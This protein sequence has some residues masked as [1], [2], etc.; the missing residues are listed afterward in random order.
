MSNVLQ[1]IG[2]QVGKPVHP[3]HIYPSWSHFFPLILKGVLFPPLAELYRRIYLKNGNIQYLHISIKYS[4]ASLATTPVDHPSLPHYQQR[5]A[6]SLYHR[7]MRLQREGDLHLATML[8][9]SALAALPPT[10]ADINAWHRPNLR[11]T[12]QSRYH[13]T[14]NPKYLDASIALSLLVISDLPEGSPQA[15]LT[16]WQTFLANSYH[17]RYSRLGKLDDLEA[18]LRWS[19]VAVDS[20]TSD[21]PLL[22]SRQATLGVAYSDRLHRY[23]NL[24]DIDL[25]LFWATSA[26]SKTP[27]TDV[28]YFARKQNLAAFYADRYKFLDNV[29]DLQRA[30]Q[31]CHEN[32]NGTEI[33]AAR[34]LQYHHNFAF[35]MWLRYLKLGA[36]DD[37]DIAIDHAL[38]SAQRSSKANPDFGLFSGQCAILFLRKYQVLGNLD[39]LEAAAKWN[40]AALHALNGG[41]PKAARYQHN[42]AVVLHRR[43]RRHRDKKDLEMA[44]QWCNTSIEQSQVD[45]PELQ[46][47]QHL[48]GILYQDLF[49]LSS[50]RSHLDTALEIQQKIVSET[51]NGHPDAA[52]RYSSLAAIYSLMYRHKGGINNREAMMKWN[53]AAADAA[54]ADDPQLYVYKNV[55]ALQYL[56]KYYQRY[57]LDHAMQDR[58]RAMGYF[59]KSS[60]TSN[61]DPSVIWDVVDRWARFAELCRSPECLDAYKAAYRTLP[62][63]FWLGSRVSSRHETLVK[64]NVTSITTKA[65]SACMAFNNLKLAVEFVEQS[66][67]LTFQQLLDLQID[68]SALEDKFP[69]HAYELQGVSA[70]LQSIA[71]STDDEADLQRKLAMERTA[72]LKTIR[73][74]PKFEN[75][76]LPAPF[77][78][79]VPAAQSGPV[80]VI[81]CSEDRCDALILRSDGT[82]IQILLPRV[83][84][85]VVAQQCEKL[86]SALRHY[87][88]HSR[89]M[90]ELDTDRA[91]RSAFLKR[92]N[93]ETIL[94]GVLTWVWSFIVS[95]IFQTLEANGIVDGRIW[96]C[97]TGSLTYLPLHAAGPQSAYVQSYTSTLSALIR[98]RSLPAPEIPAKVIAVGLSELG[99]GTRP[100]LPNVKLEIEAL[101]TAAGE[102]RVSILLNEEATLERVTDLLPQSSWL[103]LACHGRQGNAQDPLKSG[104]LL[105][106]NKKLELERLINTPIPRAEFVFLSACE[107]AMGDTDMANESLHLAGGMIFAGFKAAI[108]TLW[109]IN[110]LDGPVVAQ[111]VYSYLFKNGQE[112]EVTDTA[113][114]LHLAVNILREKGVPPHR[115]V[116]FI[117]IGI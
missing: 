34:P 87:G 47:R 94:N 3:S 95:P 72:L 41:H 73:E 28:N 117:H 16:I 103:H 36:Y 9:T 63:L 109:S 26:V 86:R 78:S 102:N 77:T 74:I 37:L 108:G 62:E 29:E 46:Q 38:Q 91:A 32:I 33:D 114:A 24:E 52:E 92:S 57:N 4:L 43:Y 58:E 79:L 42:Y 85:S 61:G 53:H 60:L 113:E 83:H 13:H 10:L 75:F 15:H 54:D 14:G 69:G 97:L 20:T 64:H 66:L 6:D 101:K 2:T 31:L 106:N 82:L 71:I 17:H 76:L 49:G 112:P 59:Q 88:I 7:Y 8:Q 11:L 55:L 115:W 44:L 99:S 111:A 67:A 96:W 110:D 48:L 68:L 80:I 100:C 81:N 22:P 50:D 27:R 1:A 56:N 39:D 12:Y 35:Y 98:A 89:Q 23:R 5:L 51:A 84:S 40:E 18:E 19:H 90:E 25:G 104:L 30:I 45:D 65:I 116:P 105:Y 107:T 70:K 93:G 21:D